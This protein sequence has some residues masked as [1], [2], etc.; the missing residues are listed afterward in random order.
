[1]I[2]TRVLHERRIKGATI[3]LTDC[4]D[5]QEGYKLVIIRE[6]GYAT[7]YE[8]MD[9]YRKAVEDARTGKCISAG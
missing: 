1:M 6:R 7:Y 5:T 8:A 4:P 3:I 9:G 2:Q